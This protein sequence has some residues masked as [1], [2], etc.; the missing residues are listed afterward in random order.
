MIRFTDAPESTQPYLLKLEDELG[1]ILPPGSLLWIVPATDEARDRAKYWLCRTA[2]SSRAVLLRAAHGAGG[3]YFVDAGVVRT[4]PG[5]L[6][7][8]DLDVVL[9]VVRD[10]AGCPGVFWRS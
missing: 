6:K 5:V 8:Q 4:L 3:L 10:V 1:D 7:V 2:N 9:G